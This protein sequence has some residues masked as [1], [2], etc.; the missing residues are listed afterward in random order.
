V[1]AI[2]GNRRD[3]DELAQFYLAHAATSPLVQLLTEQG[4]RDSP[5][6]VHIADGRMIE[7]GYPYPFETV[8]G[9]PFKPGSTPLLISRASELRK[10]T[11]VVGKPWDR[12]LARFEDP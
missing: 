11:N 5:L 12:N 2:G 3:A 1:W 6:L 7:M 10:V 8:T 9:I 4:S